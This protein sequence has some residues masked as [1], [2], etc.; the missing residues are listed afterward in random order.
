[1]KSISFPLRLNLENDNVGTL[2]EALDDLGYDIDTKERSQMK[3]GTSTRKAV[4]EF[5]K[6]EGLE[7][8]GDVENK[9]AHRLNQKLSNRISEAGEKYRVRGSVRDENWEG[10]SN[11][12]VQ[13][14][15][16][17]FDGEHL[18]IERTTFKNGFYDAIYRTTDLVQ[19]RPK[20]EANKGDETLSVRLEVRVVDDNGENLFPPKRIMGPHKVEWLNFTAGKQPYMGESTY[21]TQMKAVK[22]VLSGRLL[23]NLVETEEK[24][25][26]TVLATESGLKVDQVMRLVL[27]HR[28]TAE[29][30]IA[31]EV[32]YAL[33]AQ[34]LPAGLPEHLL[35]ATQNFERI[36]A[37]VENTIDGIA[38]MSSRL[39]E[40]AVEQAIKTNLIPR[41][42]QQKLDKW[43]EELAA[44]TR[45][46]TLDQPM[47][48]GTTTMRDIL[49][50]TKLNSDKYE[51]VAALYLDYGGFGTAF[52]KEVKENDVFESDSLQ[53]LQRTLQLGFVARNH[54][55]M[56]RVLKDRMETDAPFNEPRE[57]AWMDL[58]GW[59]EEVQSAGEEAV[60]EAIDAENTEQRM[61]LFAREL[62]QRTEL[63]FPT[64]ALTARVGRSDNGVVRH[65]EE[66]TRFVREN[67]DFDLTKEHVEGYLHNRN[68]WEN[69]F[70]K[71]DQALED[72]KRL[73]RT[74]QIE[75]VPRIAGSLLESGIHSASQIYHMGKEHFIGNYSGTE[76]LT[77]TEA[78]R[79][80]KRARHTYARTIKRIVEFD[81][82]FNRDAPRAV[83][84][85]HLDDSEEVEEQLPTLESLFGSLDFCNCSHCQSIL[86]PAAYYV[87]LLRFLAQSNGSSDSKSPVEVLLER[88]PDLERIKLDCKNTNTAL[89]YIDLTCEI[90]ERAV[91]PP[92][93]GD[94]VYYQT[95]WSSDELRAQPEHI[96]S[97]AYKVLRNA[98][99]PLS[100]P[101]DLW[102]LQARTYLDH[103][104]V[105]RRELMRAFRPREGWKPQSSPPEFQIGL[106][107]LEAESFGISAA[108]LEIIVKKKASTA[109]QK[110][111]WES[112]D[113]TTELLNME[114]FLDTARLSYDEGVRLLQ[115]RFVNPVNDSGN[116][117]VIERPVKDCAVSAQQLN[118]L[119]VGLLD[120]V[121]RFLRIWRKTDWSMY[122]LDLLLRHQSVGKGKLNSDTIRQLW[123]IKKLQEALDLGVEETL[124][125]FG[126]LNTDALPSIVESGPIV[127]DPVY[128][129]LFL[130]QTVQDPIADAF[131]V[132]NITSSGGSESIKDH[133]SAISAAF[134]LSEEEVKHLSA[135]TDGS[136]TL[137]NLSKIFRYGVTAQGLG[138]PV[139]RLL[140]LIDL[141]EIN[142]PFASPEDVRELISIYKLVDQ[143]P[144][145]L[146]QLAANLQWR[147]DSPDASSE[148]ILAG[149]VQQL[150]SSLEQIRND[151]L[152]SSEPLQD[153]LSRT[154]S[155][156]GTFSESSVLDTTH[157]I[158]DGTWDQP[159][160]DPHLTDSERKTFIRDHFDLFLDPAKAIQ[161]LATLSASSASDR[162]QKIRD[163]YLWVLQQLHAHLSEDIVI[164]RVANWLNL[165]TSTTVL[166]LRNLSLNG[167]NGTLL[168][169]L[170][171]T[172]FVEAI[173]NED[174]EFPFSA[175]DLP[176][177][178]EALRLLKKTGKLIRNR[179]LNSKD[180][181]WLLTHGPALGFSDF[182]TLPVKSGQSAA[183]FQNWQQFEELLRLKDSISEK[184][185]TSFF[186]V[187]DHVRHGNSVSDLLDE[188]A[189]LT[190]WDR[191][192]LQ[193]IHD[194][195]NLRI[196][197]EYKKPATY[198]RIHTCIEQVDRIGATA[199]SL[200]SWSRPVVTEQTAQ[201][202]KQAVKSKYDKERWLSIASPLQDTIRDKKRAALVD[203]LISHPAPADPSDPNSDPAWQDVED[204]YAYFLIDVEMTSCQLTSRIKQ[205]ISSVHLF[206][207]RCRMNLEPDVDPL[208]KT[209]WDKWE[210][211]KNYRVWEANRKV[212][213]YPENWIEPELRQKKSPF[214]ESLEDQL[215]QNE[216]TDENAEKAFRGYLDRLEDVDR[217]EV[218]GTCVQEKG[219][220]STQHVFARTLGEPPIYYHRQYVDGTSWSPWEKVDLD[221]ETEHLVPVLYQDRLYLFWLT[222]RE[223]PKKEQKT[224]PAEA[225]GS[226]SR[227]AGSR[228]YLEIQLAW[229]VFRNRKWT[230]KRV[231]SNR[232]IHPWPRPRST[233]HLKPR[234]NKA[235]SRLYLDIFIS[236]S[237]TFNNNAEEYVGVT[238][239][240]NG[241]VKFTTNEHDPSKRPWH[242]STFVFNGDVI[243]VRLK[244]LHTNNKRNGSL[245]E[246]R[247]EYGEEGSIEPL[248]SVQ[249]NIRLP[250]HQYFRNTHLVNIP[251]H[252]SLTVY[253][254]RRGKMTDVELLDDPETPYSVVINL[255][256]VQPD[257][258]DR[259]FFYQDTERSYFVE[260]QKLYRR[261]NYLTPDRTYQYHAYRVRYRFRPFYHPY[262][263]TFKRALNRAGIDEL[264]KRKMQIK[265]YSVGV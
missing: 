127:P 233:Y 89:P 252:E 42:A 60:P 219:D 206:V 227:P 221:I 14:L 258:I 100:M 140:L 8:T 58:E 36:D 222:F 149:E 146:N 151:L 152:Q 54:L 207:Q 10:M 188:M 110:K 234:W 187:L 23:A 212:F 141:A 134:G 16:K 123:N 201:Q 95:N 220:T 153:I 204:L 37:L 117:I 215:Q 49:D 240:S 113:P 74:L 174:A 17:T 167:Q 243:D 47:G 99:A 231:S 249:P 159:S 257:F 84:K 148:A 18:L 102:T 145:T 236:T 41:D 51:P 171:S 136:L 263:E 39:R 189:D 129:R 78:E 256:D 22:P 73:Q 107:Y 198:R 177:V 94:E 63:S 29:T 4:R 196:S 259:S 245:Q 114:A 247:K 157:R 55:P 13:L 27:A 135:K 139:D 2:Q 66:L 191:D 93:E 3:F 56:V 178:F 109:A 176:N 86:S 147:P 242:S 158:I 251:G 143:S 112:D 104:G 50:E 9:T 137:S 161:E 192:T 199:D 150:H 244:E 90:L 103:L 183:S 200:F 265:P 34:R 75:P 111:F 164:E 128:Q 30:E 24:N 26:L 223:R 226:S 125:L 119:N 108:E 132:A 97:E 168:D 216:L 203:Y 81:P 197:K 190:G 208:H 120:R 35:S 218:V 166:L 44:L 12:R 142:A 76:N 62:Q 69:N 31:P 124:A 172:S 217:L 225:S 185:D 19:A 205:A 160:G 170:T 239:N 237:E 211:M 82:R 70:E 180:V 246:A 186:K 5:Q 169:I 68:G 144:L 77:E 195:L 224:A 184:G 96:R 57:L 52:W 15:Q 254:R 230:P 131:E 179:S 43:T 115:S 11:V 79:V 45:T 162:E 46:S 1:M 71:P 214:F 213:L 173:P 106:P 6:K 85:N 33:L 262:V 210:W 101:F 130:N 65:K 20:G 133:R 118:R 264:L 88:R 155:S 61:E 80:F 260:P 91:A 28:L 126:D 38:L 235:S 241:W 154:L 193:S 165:S 175:G 87:D 238:D 116:R 122:E 21:V 194:G 182:N 53:D 67:P 59:K 253:T 83:G 156:I 163:R 229:S 105:S 121:N 98:R 64:E 209:N 228:Q 32:F 7:V 92:E 72:M 25:Q 40:R 232:L 250:A 138:I 202:I 48:R 255:R 181:D 261:E 248:Q